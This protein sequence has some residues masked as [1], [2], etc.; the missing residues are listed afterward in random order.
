MSFLEE[1][2]RRNVTKV[3]AL[4][5]I[6]S[7]LILQVADVLFPNLGAPDWA[8][9]LVLGLLV[10]FF[11]PALIFSWVYEMTPE[12]LKREKDIDR[13]VSITPVTSRRISLMII[14]LLTLAVA[15]AF[16]DRMVPQSDRDDSVSVNDVE[17][18]AEIIDASQLAAAKFA[19]Q[20]DRSIAVLPFANRSTREEDVFFV[21]GIHDDI[22]TQLARIG[23]LKV[24]SRT[25]VQRFEDSALSIA[26]IGAALGVGNILEGGVQRAGDRVRINVQ[27]IDVATDEHL[28]ANTYDRELTTASIFAIQ[29]EIA[30]AV[31]EALKATLSADEKTQL[32]SAQTDNMAALEAY[33]LGRQAMEKRTTAS[34]DEAEAQ[35][36]RAI[37]LDRDYALAN[38]DLAVTYSLQVNYGRRS[39]SEQQA[40]SRPLV[41][42]ALAINDRLGEAYIAMTSVTDDL[43]EKERFFRKGIDLAPGYVFGHH[44]YGSFLLRQGRIQ[45]ALVQLDQAARLDPFSSIV[46]KA[47]GS[48]LEGLGR[49]DEAREQYEKIIRIDPG[50]SLAYSGLGRLDMSAYGR[51]DQAIVRLRE[52]AS[53]DPDNP[54][55]VGWLVFMWSLIGDQTEAERMLERARTLAPDSGW[56]HFGSMFLRLN[57]GQLA[58]AAGDA[59]ALLAESPTDGDALSVLGQIDMRAGDF[60]TALERYRAA[61]PGL[62]ENAD[63]LIDYSNYRDAV[64]VAVILQQLGNNRRADLLLD[65]TMEFIQ[66][67]NRLGWDGYGITDVQIFAMRGMKD[68]A[69]AALREA[70]DSGWRTSW[71]FLLKHDAILSSLHGEPGLQV[72]VDEL[73]TDMATQLIHIREIAAEGRLT[74]LPDKYKETS[75]PAM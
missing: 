2:K 13:A 25:S 64:R 75:R 23:T 57:Q 59:E 73:E 56:T 35:F 67:M 72:I 39:R 26:E 5:V 70:V 10:L 15:V 17:P 9:A 62:I 27:L 42:R 34:L 48:A 45:E 60:E 37:E 58:E 4:Y 52:G 71:R 46:R 29:S 31:S 32:A 68:E 43:A 54:L 36:K 41:Q 28:W 33:F 50:F 19:R 55:Y 69:L 12:G 49:F 51:L 47:L 18:K 1:L 8:F 30:T 44:W 38:V 53:L 22:L 14:A 24:I 63:P 16:I 20:P 74:P 11:F 21:D 65:T 7:W 6:A 3:A 40:L 61:E 66:T